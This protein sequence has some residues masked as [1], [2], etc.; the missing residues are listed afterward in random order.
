LMQQALVAQE[1]LAQGMGEAD[2]YKGKISSAQFYLRNIVPD[3]M[4][5]ARIIQDYDTSA[6][7]IPEGAF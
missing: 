1:K 2:F 6:M 7:E 4:A 3:V 5:T